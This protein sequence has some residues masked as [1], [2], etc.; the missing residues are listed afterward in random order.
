MGS[1]AQMIG[2]GGQSILSAYSIREQGKENTRQATA[3]NVSAQFQAEQEEQDAGQVIAASQRAGA[4]Q[5][6]QAGLVASRAVAVAAATGGSASDKTVSNIVARVKGEGA[7]RHAA[8]LYQGASRARKMVI[9]AAAKR[10]EGAQGLLVAL[11]EQKVGNNMALVNLLGGFGSISS[12]YSSPSKSP[13]GGGSST[14]GTNEY[15]G[16]S[17]FSDGGGT[18]VA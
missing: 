15:A 8:I 10:Y 7:F 9:E 11:R 12:K 6:R 14:E 13:G 4:E 2:Q 3:R 18:A 1:I 17:G 16:D 5:K